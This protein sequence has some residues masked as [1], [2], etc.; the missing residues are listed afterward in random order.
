MDSGFV[1]LCIAHTPVR[2]IILNYIDGF[3]QNYCRNITA[4]FLDFIAAYYIS[5][6]GRCGAYWKLITIE[7]ASWSTLLGTSTF[8][9][10]LQQLASDSP[11]LPAD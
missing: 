7:Q 6:R 4:G 11:T 8:R 10:H 9:K 3:V 1:L 2:F 5:I